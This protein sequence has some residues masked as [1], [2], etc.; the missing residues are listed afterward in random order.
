MILNGPTHQSPIMR[1]L[2]LLTLGLATLSARPA[3]TNYV[4]AFT[5][6]FEGGTHLLLSNRLPFVVSVQ[7]DAAME[8]ATA[9]LPLPATFTLRPHSAIH[10]VTIE[11]GE[12]RRRWKL[13]WSY[14]YN[15]G[16]HRA[17]HDSNRVYRVPFRGRFRLT[18]GWNG[19]FSHSGWMRHAVDFTMPQGTD[20]C[21]A[22]DGV[23]TR[24]VDHFKE[25]GNSPA[26]KTKANEI[27]IGHADGTLSQY[28]HLQYQGVKVK[29]GQQV[30]A[31]Q[32]IGLSG[33][34]GFSTQ[35]HL[36]F[37]VLKSAAATNYLTLPFRF[38]EGR[39]RERISYR[40]EK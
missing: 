17:N 7:V 21:A 5:D 39:P 8:N 32:I 15:L 40:G 13:D 22:R 31:G 14:R 9:D 35:P 2:L 20:V 38:P 30:K 25:G 29:I 3:D 24:A 4:K 19:S 28:T 18:Q 27:M 23:V 1:S 36:H 10:A 33:N 34:T 26:F 16:D 6:R 11:Q 12:P 37:A